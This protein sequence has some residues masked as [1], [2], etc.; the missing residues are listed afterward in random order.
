[1]IIALASS[2]LIPHFQSLKSDDSLTQSLQ[3]EFNKRVD[4][5]KSL[6]S[7]DQNWYKIGFGTLALVAGTFSVFQG[8]W[9]PLPSVKTPT[10]PCSSAKEAVARY[11]PGFGFMAVGTGLIYK[12]IN[13]KKA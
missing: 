8:G 1:M 3:K 11:A 6:K 12:G 2:V 10:K 13:D 5:F 7:A 4:Q 9:C